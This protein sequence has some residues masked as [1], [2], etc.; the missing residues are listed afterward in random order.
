MQTLHAEFVMVLKKSETFEQLKSEKT[1]HV[2]RPSQLFQVD[3]KNCYAQFNDRAYF[4]H[5]LI[6]VCC[7]EFF[8]VGLKH[9]TIIILSTRASSRESCGM[10]ITYLTIFIMEENL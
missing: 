1:C 5:E 4:A 3:K 2:S 8:D 9:F 10:T 6:L 7:R